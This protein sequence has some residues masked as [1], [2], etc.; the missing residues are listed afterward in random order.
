[1]LRQ[2][3]FLVLSVALATLPTFAQGTSIE[4]YLIRPTPAIDP[5]ARG[6]ITLELDSSGPGEKF[7]VRIDRVDT[8]SQSYQLWLEEPLGSGLL[9]TV[10]SFDAD[11]RHDDRAEY[12]RRTDRGASLP[13]NAPN[14]AALKDRQLEVRDGSGQAILLGTVPD[15]GNGQSNS[16]NNRRDS[17]ETPLQ[18]PS[19]APLP[20]A[21]GSVQAQL[22]GN[23]SELEIETEDFDVA[24]ATFR[25]W[26]ADAQA[27]MVEI[28]TLA[29]DRGRSD[30]GRAEWRQPGNGMPLGANS[31]SE[32]IGRRVEIRNAND[33]VVLFGAIPALGTANSN[34]RSN[35]RLG[36]ESSGGQFG[37]KGQSK[38]SWQ[39]AR[40]RF[41]L[42]VR[43]FATNPSSDAELWIQHP[44][45]GLF[46]L[47]ATESWTG[48]RVRK[49]LFRWDSSRSQA[50]PFGVTDP[51]VLL[52]LPIEV[53][54]ASGERLLSGNL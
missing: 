39:A 34:S 18:R 33:E 52:G 23:Q 53:R 3:T 11:S 17:S 14:L 9:T 29:P 37:A 1:M 27:V 42:D 51:S 32:L 35:Q 49:A 30:H 46:E 31:I 41:R 20:Q 7:R 24:N 28:G 2:P 4:A 22:Q 21:Q 19:P 8:S 38:T 40:G 48:G 10:G 13:L 50:L 26:L 16:G 45:S 5:D 6:Q 44:T 12:E 47:V 36:R 25:V 54:L 15:I 43:A